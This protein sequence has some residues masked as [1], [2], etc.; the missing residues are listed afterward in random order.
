MYCLNGNN[1]NNNRQDFGV[2]EICI[3]N[4]LVASHN[5]NS[6]RLQG[7]QGYIWLDYKIVLKKNWKIL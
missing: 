1:Y 6:L 3:I 5:Y 7:S 2:N 4:V